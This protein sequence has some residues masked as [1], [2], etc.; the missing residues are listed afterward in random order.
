MNIFSNPNFSGNV[1]RT[2]TVTVL[3]ALATSVDWNEDLK[4]KN[5]VFFIS[6]ATKLYE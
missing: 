2:K 4:N 5:S 3:G 6:T 1:T